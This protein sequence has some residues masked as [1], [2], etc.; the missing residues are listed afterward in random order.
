MR[1]R[2]IAFRP[3][4]TSTCN[5]IKKPC[6]IA[7]RKEENNDAVFKYIIDIEIL[8][9]SRHLFQQIRSNCTFGITIFTK[10][11]IF[12]RIFLVIFPDSIFANRAQLK[13]Y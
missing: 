10:C 4:M 7:N 5:I 13:E 11:F 12:K 9:V 3:S 1:D 6:K 8:D 2:A